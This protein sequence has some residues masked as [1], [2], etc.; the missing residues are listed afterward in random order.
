MNSLQLVNCNVEGW[1]H[2][3]RVRAMLQEVQPDV[4]C[5]QEAPAGYIETISL[6]QDF[7]YQLFAPIVLRQATGGDPFPEGVLI[8]SKLPFETYSVEYY[9]RPHQHLRVFDDNQKRDTIDQVCLFVQIG[10]FAIATTHFTWTPNG[11]APCEYQRTDQSRLLAWLATQ[12]PHLLCG[13]MNIPRHH[14]PLYEQFLT[15]YID[16]IPELYASSLDATFHRLGSDPTRAHLFR[17]FMVDYV[18]TQ[19][20]YEALNTTLRF[21]VSDHAAVIGTIVRA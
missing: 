13:D 14:N 5:L 10:S 1:K 18:F 2:G 4:V 15:Q 3:D 12:P 16:A 8:A 9:H 20:P 6:Q 19:A 17:D 11:N 21:G 7:P